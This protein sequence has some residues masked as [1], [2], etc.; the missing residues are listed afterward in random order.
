MNEDL[1]E[2][3]DGLL[4]SVGGA[5]KCML[6]EIGVASEIRYVCTKTEVEM[7]VWV[8]NTVFATQKVAL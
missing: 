4:R 8:G 7:Q 6:D 5:T 3:V 1:K 2:L